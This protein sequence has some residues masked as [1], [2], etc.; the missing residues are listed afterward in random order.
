MYVSFKLKL[1][2]LLDGIPIQMRQ[3]AYLVQLR[4]LEL[5]ASIAFSGLKKRFKF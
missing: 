5:G 1:Y 3:I 2:I 4:E